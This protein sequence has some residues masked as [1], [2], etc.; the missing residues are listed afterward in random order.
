MKLYYLTLALLTLGFA[1]GVISPDR[2]GLAVLCGL[3]LS[4][5]AALEY[6]TNKPNDNGR[7]Q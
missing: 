4:G 5:F 3:L 6:F 7:D 1:W 2:T